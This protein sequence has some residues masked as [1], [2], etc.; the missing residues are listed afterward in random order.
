MGFWHT[1]YMEFHEASGFEITWETSKTVYACQHCTLQFDEIDQLRRHRF[2]AHPYTRPLF[3]VRGVELGSTSICI[4][5]PVKTEDFVYDNCESVKLNGSTIDLK[6]MPALLCKF[7][8][9]KVKIT[10]INEAVEASFE[11]EFRIA[12]GEHLKG[13]EDAFMMLAKCKIL[14]IKSIESF[15][16]NCRAFTTAGYYYDGICHYLYGV[17]AKEHSPDS[18]LKYEEYQDRFNRAASVLADYDRP[19]ARIIR[20]LVAFH[21]N[22]FADAVKL[23]PEGRLRKAAEQYMRLLSGQA[24][25]T[26]GCVFEQNAPEDL[27]TDHE[28]LRIVRW[29]TGDLTEDNAHDIDALLKRDIP[30]YDRLKLRI[31][32][33][34]ALFAKR[35]FDLAKK[36]TRELIGNNQ[37]QLWAEKMLARID[38]KGV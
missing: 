16:E 19:L 13:V 26:V 21:F 11:L 3:Y 9:D 20:A 2:E 12:Q 5:S 18:N 10:L 17:L 15:I 25:Q 8:N 28:N 23:A 7:S 14:S 35:H 33:A 24:K 6:T 31:I 37:T 27:L 29:A 1:G 32:L 22:H 38:E 30:E 4:T 36:A 34:E